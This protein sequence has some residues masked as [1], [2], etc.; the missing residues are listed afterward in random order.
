MPQR[1]VRTSV[2]LPARLVL[3]ILD[4]SPV[5]TDDE[6]A[7]L[8]TINE[9]IGTFVNDIVKRGLRPLRKQISAEVVADIDSIIVDSTNIED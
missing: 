1:R 8:I 9:H 7:P 3:V 2:T 4:V 5:P 6:G